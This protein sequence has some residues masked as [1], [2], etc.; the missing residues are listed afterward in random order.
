MSNLPANNSDDEDKV[1]ITLTR[2]Q[3]SDFVFTHVQ[4]PS[5]ELRTVDMGFD[6]TKDKLKH[7]VDKLNYYID[8]NNRLLNKEFSATVY[9]K[10]GQLIKRNS[11]D[12]FFNVDGFA[13][14]FV[15][16]VSVTLSYLIDFNS[17]YES[18]QPEKQVIVLRFICI[19]NKDSSVWTEIRTTEFTWPAPIFQLIEKELD[20][21]SAELQ[22]KNPISSSPF[23]LPVKIISTSKYIQSK[24][25]DVASIMVI[26]FILVMLGAFIMNIRASSAE[27]RIVQIYDSASE[28]FIPVETNEYF[29]EDDWRERVALVRDS[30]NLRSYFNEIPSEDSPKLG[31]F[32][33]IKNILLATPA[34]LYVLMTAVSIWT[35]LNLREFSRFKENKVGRIW[36][37]KRD[38]P[39]RQGRSHTEGIATSIA[40]G[41]MGS[42]LFAAFL[43]SLTSILS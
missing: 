41:F 43:A 34:W 3:F 1:V 2:K 39:A 7:I 42:A 27:T 15:E 6:L 35:F 22:E 36:L 26:S 29:S 25:V 12:D 33:L 5:E 16:T 10:E 18:S 11:Y 21:L 38:I 40:I 28:S 19:E 31:L 9:V 4:T 23:F 17:G 32:S 8:K 13:S 30:R 37:T 20:E 14:G 24:L